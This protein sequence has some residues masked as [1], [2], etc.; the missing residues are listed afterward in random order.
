MSKEWYDDI[1]EQGIL[2]WVENSNGLRKVA[3][4]YERV[5]INEGIDNYLEQQIMYLTAF[6]WT[7]AEPIPLTN[8][9]IEE[10]KR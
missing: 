5:D 9:E 10:F 6:F 3:T 8:E 4:V 1:P 7:Q 2:C